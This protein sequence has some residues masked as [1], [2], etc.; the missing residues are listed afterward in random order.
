MFIPDTQTKTSFSQLQNDFKKALK[1]VFYEENR[2]EELVQKRLFPEEVIRKI[3]ATNPLSVAIPKEYGGHGCK[4]GECLSVMEAASY[5][6]LPLSLIMGIN[7]A[8]FLQPVAKYGKE[9]VKGEIF[10]RFLNE[11][12]MGGLMIT[13]PDYGSDAMNMQTSH[14]KHGMHYHI[15]GTKHWQGLTG[16]ADYWIMTARAKEANGNLKR[17]LDFFICDTHKPEQVIHVKEYYNN[18]G[19]YPIPYGMNHVDIKVPEV[20][21]LQPESTGLKLMMDLLHRSR[22]QFPGMGMGYIKRI[23]EEAVDHCRNRYIGGKSILSLDQVQLLVTRIQS[24]FTICS[25]MCHKSAKISGIE[26]NLSL[27]GVEANSVKAH[28]SD[29]M[30]ECAQ[31]LTQLLGA[32]G[33][34][35]ESLGARGII[36]SRPFQIFEGSN[37]MLYTQISDSILKMMSRVQEGNLFKFLK[38]YD[39]TKEA[40]G[41]FKSILNF[42]VEPNISQRKR[43][44]LGRVI[45]KLTSAEY[46]MNLGNSGF[47][48]DLVNSSLKTLQHEVSLVI[49]SYNHHTDTEVIDH[50]QDNS[51]WQAYG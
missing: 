15:S 5:E 18:V 21:K 45:S 38:S 26:N 29:L 1:N 31:I 36:D 23:M 27:A 2:I 39:L 43:V 41:F 8:L 4:P 42:N 25:A 22:L 12:N 37:D 3:M 48:T 11:Q 33:Y 9:E 6:S 19:L 28:I 49:N 7:M 10:S 20:N 24:A 35:T 32:N 46:V 51:A 50:Y 44:D 17:D 40:A 13:E 30:Q 47:N 14:E 34:K 16:M